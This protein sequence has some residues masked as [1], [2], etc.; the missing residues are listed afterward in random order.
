MPK[1]RQPIED[2]ILEELQKVF[3]SE[4]TTYQERV[5]V[6]THWESGDSDFCV[7]LAEEKNLMPIA[8]ICGS[9][10]DTEHPILCPNG[11]LLTGSITKLAAIILRVETIRITG[12]STGTVDKPVGNSEFPVDNSVDNLVDNLLRKFNLSTGGTGLVD[13]PES[14]PHPVDNFENL[15]TVPVD[16]HKTSTETVTSSNA[17]RE[18]LLIHTIHTPYYDYESNYSI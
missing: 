2:M 12:L 11:R 9:I 14:Y 3:L 4:A 7:R 5:E 16:N 15:P 1:R 10:I 13:I 8:L 17:K 6:C 18:D